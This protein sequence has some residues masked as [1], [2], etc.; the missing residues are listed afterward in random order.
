M[1][2]LLKFLVLLA[3]F[4]S[5]SLGDA[6][7][8]HARLNH[9][10]R[11]DA[12]MSDP[13]NEPSREPNCEPTNELSI[14]LWQCRMEI[15]TMNTKKI[16][17]HGKCQ[18]KISERV[19]FS[20]QEKDA[21]LPYHLLPE[22]TQQAMIINAFSNDEKTSVTF[23]LIVGFIQKFQSQMQQDLVNLSLSNAFSIAKLD[24]IS[25]KAKSNS[26]IL[27][28]LSTSQRKA[29]IHFYDGSSQN[30]SSCASLLAARAKSQS[31][32]QRHVKFIV[33]LVSEGARNA[34]TIFQTF[35]STCSQFI[36]KKNLLVRFWG[37]AHSNFMQLNLFQ[38]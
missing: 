34:P 12:S 35:S 32:V 2:A 37:R 9:L 19:T 27:I 18:D 11:F 22:H 24:S 30:E 17:R 10:I 28:D 26:A 5:A 29:K 15:D 21:E 23:R 6:F 38:S 31:E 3:I 13:T 36:V 33:E 7:V 20:K 8:N 1:T 25:I 14:D 16:S 4:L